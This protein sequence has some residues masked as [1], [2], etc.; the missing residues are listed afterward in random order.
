V[1]CHGPALGDEETAV[2]ASY[3]ALQEKASQAVTSALVTAF[4]HTTKDLDVVLRLLI[5]V[6]KEVDEYIDYAQGRKADQQGTS[7]LSPSLS[8]PVDA[9]Y[10]SFAAL[11]ACLTGVSK[12]AP[13][14]VRQSGWLAL[15]KLRRGD[16]SNSNLLK[17]FLQRIDR[18][19]RKYV[20]SGGDKRLFH[21]LRFWAQHYGKIFSFKAWSKADQGLDPN[22]KSKSHQCKLDIL[23]DIEKW[24]SHDVLDLFVSICKRLARTAHETMQREG[25]KKGSS[26]WRL[27]LKSSILMK[28]LPLAFFVFESYDLYYNP[29]PPPTPGLL[30][31]PCG[32][33]YL[34]KLCL[35]EEEKR[36]NEGGIVEGVFL[37]TEMLHH[38]GKSLSEEGALAFAAS[39]IHVIL[40]TVAHNQAHFAAMHDDVLSMLV[41]VFMQ[42][43]R[44][45]SLWNEMEVNVTKMLTGDVNPV[46]FSLILGPWSE[47]LKSI[48]PSEANKYERLDT[49]RLAMAHLNHLI[50]CMVLITPNM[51]QSK[52]SMLISEQLAVVVCTLVQQSAVDETMLVNALSSSSSTPLFQ[53]GN[54]KLG[55]SMTKLCLFQCYPRLMSRLL[56]K[57]SHPNDSLDEATHKNNHS[58]V[59]TLLDRTVQ[60]VAANS[61]SSSHNKRKYRDDSNVA[62]NTLEQI[63]T[64]K[65]LKPWHTHTAVCAFELLCSNT[66]DSLSNQEAKSL[67]RVLAKYANNR[68]YQRYLA[69]ILRKLPVHIDSEIRQ[70]LFRHLLQSRSF[71][72]VHLG[73]D[74]LVQVTT[75]LHEV[76][77]YEIKDLVPKQIFGDNNYKT[78]RLFMECLQEHVKKDSFSK[79]TEALKTCKS[80]DRFESLCKDLPWCSSLSSSETERKETK[81]EILAFLRNAEHQLSRAQTSMKDF[82]GSVSPNPLGSNQQESLDSILSSVRKLTNQIVS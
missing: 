31:S 52:R 51:F 70:R 69:R 21:V 3:V 78:D 41:S 76:H 7:G 61:S 80:A 13:V 59:K 25:E 4:K 50:K 40:D 65:K 15:F 49:G 64:S 11:N 9:Q 58:Q 71:A 43:M 33:L 16:D 35:E 47:A 10:K 8:P 24:V 6:G 53:G 29:A 22:H 57:T 20:A 60:Q 18:E 74:A 23:S 62:I 27:E 26:G 38:Y 56:L 75:K 45:R 63:F 54:H 81:E 55:L 67:S 12:L 14:L 77:D 73:M 44:T 30:Q 2:V 39:K 42:C 37:F 82:S 79:P 72:L 32:D 1:L 28:I 66:P 34:V 19:I 46:K 68:H 48:R 36:D 5:Q 17:W